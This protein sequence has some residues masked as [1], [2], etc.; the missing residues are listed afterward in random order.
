MQDYFKIISVNFRRGRIEKLDYMVAYARFP[1]PFNMPLLPA[2]TRK[3]LYIYKPII[4]CQK[5]N[6]G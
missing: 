2:R 3:A 4:L 5:L 1:R 6:I